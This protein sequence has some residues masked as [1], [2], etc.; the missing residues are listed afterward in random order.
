MVFDDHSLAI[1][2]Q[3][4]LSFFAVFVSFICCY[5]LCNNYYID[6]NDNNDNEDND[7]D[8]DQHGD[9]GNRNKNDK[10]NDNDNDQHYDKMMMIKIIEMIT[11]KIMI[12][13]TCSCYG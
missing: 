8:N 1:F 5:C 10:D 2:L 12:I 4:P 6:V 7:N 11:L 3:I 13:Y 9:Q